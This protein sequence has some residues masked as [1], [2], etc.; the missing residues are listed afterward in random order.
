MKETISAKRKNDAVITVCQDNL[1]GR[2]FIKSV[3]KAAEKITGYRQLELV[4]KNFDIILPEERADVLN[5]Y[6]DY[7]DPGNDFATV[8]RK[9]A[10]FKILNRNGQQI[11]VSLK[12]F[13]LVSSDANKI[14]FELLMRDITL[15]H[16]L[17]ELKDLVASN[18]LYKDKNKL[19]LLSETAIIENLNI[20][21]TFCKDYYLEISVAMIAIDSLD[22]MASNYGKTAEEMV[23]QISTKVK[24]YFRTDD[25]VGLVDNKYICAILFDCSASDAQKALSR[26]KSRIDS[27]SV[28][29]NNNKTDLHISTGYMQIS[30][31][32][33]PKDI[34]NKC[35]NAIYKAQ[36][37]GGGRIYEV[38]E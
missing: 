31:N 6:I 28:M 36:G 24:K 11:P 27:N 32:D 5:S 2:V 38:V 33:Q 20:A 37:A 19:G 15:I 12:I 14:T 3:N 10:D 13:Y 1:S 34:L 21:T 18:E 4:D 23:E 25:L 8:L 22:D 17:A 29:L 30:A 26:V 35:K 9:I 16:K 7:K